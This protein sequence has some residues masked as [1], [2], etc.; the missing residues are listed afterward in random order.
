MIYNIT[1]LMCVMTM[2]IGRM[3]APGICNDIV[4]N[5]VNTVSRSLR[6]ENITRE[7]ISLEHETNNSRIIYNRP[8][9]DCAKY[10]P[11]LYFFKYIYSI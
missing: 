8:R 7:L 5:A 1:C 10:M 4:T 9:S 6:G 3:L 2:V 11:R